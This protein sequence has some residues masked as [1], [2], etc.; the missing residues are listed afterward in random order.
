MKTASENH[1]SSAPS[2]SGTHWLKSQASASGAW[3][4][5]SVGRAGGTR[6]MSSGGATSSPWSPASDCVGVD[7]GVGFGAGVDGTA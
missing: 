2:D 3:G 4:A 1:A 6:A 7:V 5:L